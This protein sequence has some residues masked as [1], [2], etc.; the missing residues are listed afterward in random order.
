MVDICLC[1]T[2][3]GSVSPRLLVP[4]F[5]FSRGFEEGVL[6]SLLRSGKKFWGEWDS[7]LPKKCWWGFSD[8]K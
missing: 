3:Q 6:N 7:S 2:F 5:T 4:M 1:K 8:G